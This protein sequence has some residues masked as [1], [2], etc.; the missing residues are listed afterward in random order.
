MG[1]PWL[2]A[3]FREAAEEMFRRLAATPFASETRESLDRGRTLEQTLRTLAEG[4]G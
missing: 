4:R 3:G 2:P 1:G